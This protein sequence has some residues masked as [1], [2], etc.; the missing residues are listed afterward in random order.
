MNLKNHNSLLI[1]ILFGATP[2]PVRSN[3]ARCVPSFYLTQRRGTY[4]G[5]VDRGVQL[6]IGVAPVAV[7]VLVCQITTVA[8]K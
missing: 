4:F 5:M 2:P 1:F 7:E 8:K 3:M 6:L